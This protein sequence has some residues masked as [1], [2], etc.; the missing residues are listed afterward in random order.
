MDFLPSKKTPLPTDIVRLDQRTVDASQPAAIQRSWTEIEY[1]Q[2]E[3]GAFAGEFSEI[4]FGNTRL[5]AEEQNRT[6]LKQG[7][8]PADRFNVAIVRDSDAAARWNTQ[9][10]RKPA[11]GYM[12]G[13]LEFEVM[14]PAS[15][16]AFF[17][18]DREELL[19]AA[20]RDGHW[21][22]DKVAQPVMRDIFYGHALVEL[23]DTL[24]GHDEA[25]LATLGAD[26]LGRLVLDRTLAILAEPLGQHAEPCPGESAACRITRAAREFIDTAQTEPLTVLDLCQTLN[27]SRRTLQY[28]FMQAY[29]I[30]PLSYLRLVRLNRARRDLLAASS[31]DTTVTEIALHWGFCHL[32]RFAQS[33]RQLFGELPSDTLRRT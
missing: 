1:H 16:I 30:A 32:A 27:V 13:G 25:S 17:S 23:A 29:G 20:A 12:P 2:M 31:D 6:V 3:S 14:L 5:V 19:S 8:L 21:I 26:Y 18:F 22:N 24:L 4:R 33:Y 15:K 7:I 10:I 11:V 9:C 28:S